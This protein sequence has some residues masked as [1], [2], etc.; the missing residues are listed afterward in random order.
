[1]ETPNNGVSLPYRYLGNSGLKVSTLCLG[2]MTFGIREVSKQKINYMLEKRKE[3][4]GILKTGVCR[5]SW[6]K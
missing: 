3:K 5:R 4:V 1:M 6:L 2:T